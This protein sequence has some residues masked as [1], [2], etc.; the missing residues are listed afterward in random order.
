MKKKQFV[1]KDPALQKD[2]LIVITGG[3]GFI[4]GNLALYFKK[5]GFTR[6][7]VVDK[8]PLY[9]WYLKVPDVE[10]LCLDVSNEDNCHHVCEGAVEVYNLAAD[11]G[12]WASSSVSV[13]NASAV[14]SSIRI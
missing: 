13:W 12:G 6:I 5:K 1:E 7:R 2:D 3:G 4:A 9:E 11:M 10:S 14:C 8:K